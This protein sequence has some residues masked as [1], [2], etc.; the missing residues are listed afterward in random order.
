MYTYTWFVSLPQC[1]AV[2]CS[3][4]QCVTVCFSVLQCV[5]VCC[6]VLQC[7]AVSHS[8]LCTHIH[9]LCL[10]LPQV[11]AEPHCNTLQHTTTQCSTLQHNQVSPFRSRESLPRAELT[12][13]VAAPHC[14]TLQHTATHY[15][16]VESLPSDF[17]SFCREK[18]WLH[19]RHNCVPCL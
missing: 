2:C 18:S 6:S 9:G 12:P 17:D 5:A 3:V 16:T 8:V 10:S 19:N 4:S 1:V 13:Y 14:M 15:N 11:V 7:A